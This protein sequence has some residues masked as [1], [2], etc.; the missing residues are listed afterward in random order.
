[1]VLALAVGFCLHYF[2]I[3]MT[4]GEMKLKLQLEQLK[5][6]YDNYQ[7]RV[8]AHFK[9]ST[10]LL[11]EYKRCQDKLEQHV[12]SAQNNFAKPSFIDASIKDN[13]KNNKS[14]SEP[15]LD[16]KNQNKN[17]NQNKDYHYS[18]YAFHDQQDQS[19]KKKQKIGA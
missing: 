17:K 8:S 6:E 9:K 12:F 14:K 3:R 18:E 10:N 4:D 15:K 11:D 19:D 2:F 5:K 16:Y 13:I 7:E 1:M